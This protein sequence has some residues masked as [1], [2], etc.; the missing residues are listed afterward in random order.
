MK[1]LYPLVKPYRYTNFS[2]YFSKFIKQMLHRYK[3]ENHHQTYTHAPGE[4]KKLISKINKSV[5]N[6][7]F[8]VNFHNKYSIRIQ[9]SYTT[10]T[11]IYISVENV[12]V[13][14]FLIIFS[15]FLYCMVPKN[16][17]E[18]QFTIQ[19]FMSTYLYK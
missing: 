14:W 17:Y 3:I 10:H 6:G 18:N 19:I 2:I 11:D 8:V 4:K 5:E 1:N 13:E 16:S 15:T 9:Y 7:L 12:S